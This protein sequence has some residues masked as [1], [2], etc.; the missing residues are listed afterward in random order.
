MLKMSSKEAPN[1]FSFL[2][3]S[4]LS[5]AAGRPIRAAPLPCFPQNAKNGKNV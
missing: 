5:K 2:L 1:S 4:T 3:L